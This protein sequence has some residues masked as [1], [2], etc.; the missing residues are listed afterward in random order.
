MSDIED[1]D[2]RF[3]ELTAQID[4][5]EQRKMNKAAAQE[6]ARLPRVRRRRNRRIAAFAVVAV[7]AGAGLFVAYR[8]EVVSMIPGVV[9]E[10]FSDMDLGALRL[11]Q[12]PEETTPVDVRPLKVSP[13]EG[14]P[15]KNYAD[16]AKGLVMPAARATGGLSRKDV[17]TAL[18]RTRDMLKASHLDRRTLMGGRPTAL[19]KLLHPEQREWFLKNLDRGK[20]KKGVFNS[21]DWVT[22]LAPKTAELATDVIKVKG[23]TKYSTFQQKGRSG[24]RITVNYLFVY[25]IHRPGRPEPTERIIAHNLGEVQVYRENGKLVIWPVTWNADGVAGSRCDV[26]DGFV[27]PFYSDSAPDEEAAKVTTAPVDPYELDGD[28]ESEDCSLTIGT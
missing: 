23:K 3:N 14:S 18:Q 20:P 15:A 27:H 19:A 13:F 22:S 1:V 9:S 26:Y 12:V 2:K 8:P 21:R 4:Q 6:W 11:G 17:A 7:V 24:A 28:V 5:N 10:R 25:A 16:G